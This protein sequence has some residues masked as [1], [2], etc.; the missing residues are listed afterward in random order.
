MNGAMPERTP[1]IAKRF[2]NRRMR[3]IA[4]YR[5]GFEMRVKDLE[6]RKENLRLKREKRNASSTRA[7]RGAI[8]SKEFLMRSKG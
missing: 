5:G 1:P 8:K 2:E 4:G 3:T 6:L 7:R